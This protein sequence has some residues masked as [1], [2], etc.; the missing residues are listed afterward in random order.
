MGLPH[1]NHTPES[2][3]KFFWKVAP[4]FFDSAKL[5]FHSQAGHSSANISTSIIFKVGLFLSTSDL[6][7]IQRSIEFNSECPIGIR[8]VSIFFSLYLQ[9]LWIRSFISNCFDKTISSDICK[10]YIFHHI[11]IHS[12]Q[13]IH[14]FLFSSKGWLS[15]WIL[16]FIDS[17]TLFSQLITTTD[18]SGN[19]GRTHNPIFRK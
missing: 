13:A 5:F 15:I 12:C 14:E 11:L 8:R 18:L 9:I 3:F 19:S 6:T 16:W 10:I 1:Q 2:L 17:D 4:L 7:K